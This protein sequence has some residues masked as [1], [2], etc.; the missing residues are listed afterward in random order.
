MTT[1]D[2]PSDSL[3]NFERLLARRR[4]IRDYAET[5]IEAAALHRLL[6]AGQGFTAGDGKR[7]APSA[8]ALH[9]L[10][11]FAVARR[12]DGLAPG[13]YGYD[14]GNRQLRGIAPPLEAGALLSTSLADDTW[15]E[16]AP[17]VIVIAADRAAAI[18]HF[19][20]QSP[21]GMRGARYVDVETGACAQNMA[22]AAAALQLGGVFVM[23]VDERRLAQVLPLP[24]P[25]EPVALFC[26]GWP[27]G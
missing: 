22:L 17:A 5:P 11:L 24:A 23:G 1:Y 14:V 15:L 9:P 8:H 10:A 12:V 3:S 2:A 20:D 13:C 18:R 19:A 21:D 27:G 25:F 16:T 7:A 6:A 26:V 4:S